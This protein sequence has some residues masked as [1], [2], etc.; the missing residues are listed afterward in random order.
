MGK[1]E[2]TLMHQH[3]LKLVNKTSI[4]TIE[5]KPTAIITDT[6][7]VQEPIVEPITESSKP[8]VEC[9]KCKKAKKVKKF[10]EM[11]IGVRLK[12]TNKD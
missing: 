1:N 9:T 8:A 7:T 3:K 6:A 12:N 5:N 10:S 4:E 11:R 2:R